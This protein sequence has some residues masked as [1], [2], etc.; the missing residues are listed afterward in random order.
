MTE[1]EK[2]KRGHFAAAKEQWLKVC[3]AYPNLSGSDM[4]VVVMLSTYMNFKTQNAWPSMNRLAADTN[5]SR[6]TVWRSLK[7]LE[8]LKLVD[9]VHGRGRNK[10]NRYR[11][12]L[13]LGVDL[14]ALRRR[15]TPR[16]KMLRARNKKAAK[17]HTIRCEPAARL[18]EEE[19]KNLGAVAS[20]ANPHLR[21]HP[22]SL[23]AA[24]APTTILTSS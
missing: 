6:S 5:R 1:E 20:K 23:K 21:A 24:A 14:K 8:E 10:V 3:A 11:P 22:V 13:G 17:S 7:R 2:K 4:S 19:E 9:V 12:S 15:T 16:G 18:S